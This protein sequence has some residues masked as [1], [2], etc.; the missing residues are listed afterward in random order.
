VEPE[1][2]GDVVAFLCG[3]ASTSITGSSFL[4]DGGWTAA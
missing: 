3:P 4:L 2:V 1:E